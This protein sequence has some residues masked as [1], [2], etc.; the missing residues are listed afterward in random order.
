MLSCR[1]SKGIKPVLS[2]QR[3]P[4]SL[5]K[6]EWDQVTCS[7]CLEYPHNAVLLLCSSYD[8]GCRPYMCSTGRRYSNCLEQ[9]KKAYMKLK[10]VEGTS[11]GNVP[12]NHELATANLG[13]MGEKVQVPELLCPLCRGQVKG[14]TVVE[15]AR[16]Y[17]NGKKRMCIQEK[18]MFSG[19]YKELRKHVR[20]EHPWARPRAVDPAL[21]EKWKRLEQQRERN[22]VISTI[23]SSTPGAVVLGDYVIERNPLFIDYE[24]DG[25]SSDDLAPLENLGREFVT[26]ALMYGDGY[27]S[28]EENLNVNRS[29]SSRISLTSSRAYHSHLY[30]VMAIGASLHVSWETWSWCKSL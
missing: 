17:F 19:N 5:K 4:K 28:S 7:V 16:K 20:A 2:K 24:W 18:C 1:S 9:Y 10:E 12:A 6:K 8:K 11:L 26:S 21:E 14:C 22:D 25:Y 13:N 15:T 29:R 30:F 23:I 3:K 27:G